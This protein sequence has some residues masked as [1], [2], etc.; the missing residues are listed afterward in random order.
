MQSPCHLQ[1]GRKCG[2][3]EIFHPKIVKSADSIGGVGRHGGLPAARGKGQ[4]GGMAEDLAAFVAAMDRCWLERRFED[5]AAYLAE[6]VVMAAPGGGR[7][8]GLASAVESYREFM[9]R[10][11]IARFAA[12]D[13]AV[14][15]RGDT[16]YTQHALIRNDTVYVLGDFTTIGSIDPDFNVREQVRELLA[17]WKK[18]HPRLLERFDLDGNG[19]LDLQEW[20]LARQQARREVERRRDE[21]MA[22]PEAHLVRRPSA[23][24]LYLISDFDPG[25]IARR[26]RWLAL[27]HIVLFLAAIAGLAWF[28]QVGII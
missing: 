6:D 8:E 13:H 14:T 1:S 21:A 18:D 27:F 20:E 15:L 25:R 7:V 19:E 24:R 26:Y 3:L 9:S 4:N 11:R 22:A 10:S 17:S 5:L 16:R 2:G 12:R 23:G 28:S